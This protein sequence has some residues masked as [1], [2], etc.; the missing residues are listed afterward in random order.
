MGS[1]TFLAFHKEDM[2]VDYLIML[3]GSHS[4]HGPSSLDRIEHPG[5]S[6]RNQSNNHRLQLLFG[7]D[8]SKPWGRLMGLCK[9][10]CNGSNGESFQVLR[11]TDRLAF[12]NS[13][14]SAHAMPDWVCAWFSFLIFTER[15]RHLRE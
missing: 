15:L 2:T 5:S 10:I 12:R 4:R 13:C 7:H 14:S 8:A 3:N 1:S 9:D 6:G 11:A